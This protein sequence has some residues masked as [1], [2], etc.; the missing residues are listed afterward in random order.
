M[1]KYKKDYDGIIINMHN[2]YLLPYDWRMLKSQLIAESNLDLNAVSYCGAKGLAQFMPDT[3]AEIAEKA[4]PKEKHSI[5][6][7]EQSIGCCAFYMN[8]LFNQWKPSGRTMLDRYCLA[9]ASYNAG[10]GNILDAQ[11]KSGGQMSYSGIIKHLPDITGSSNAK[12]TTSYVAKILKTWHD[13][14]I[15]EH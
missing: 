2:R 13:L 10:L 4:F 1:E 3:F 5:I 15:N 7:P 14:T 9:L 8:T 12:Q 11:K 6:D